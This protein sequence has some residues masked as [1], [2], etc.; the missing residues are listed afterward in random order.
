MKTDRWEM[1]KDDEGGAERCFSSAFEAR[2]QLLHTKLD[3]NL[4]DTP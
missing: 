3:V 2:S 4:F 1:S